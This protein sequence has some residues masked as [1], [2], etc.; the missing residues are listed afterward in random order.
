MF[1][2]KELETY[3]DV[4]NAV[5]AETESVR[6]WME[7]AFPDNSKQLDFPLA[8]QHAELLV[9]N[10]QALLTEVKGLSYE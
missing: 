4:I 9:A 5:N 2:Y 10:A 8:I 7:G 3:G 6:Y 1:T